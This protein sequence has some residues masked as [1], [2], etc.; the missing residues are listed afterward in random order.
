LASSNPWRPGSNNVPLGPDSTITYSSNTN[1]WVNVSVPNL[2]LNGVGP[3]N[4]PAA[5]VEVMNANAWSA[6][7]S[8]IPAWTSMPG[9]GNYRCV[10]G[11]VAGP[12]PLSPV[13][14]GTISAGPAVSDY[15]WMTGGTYPDWTT[16]N[17]RVSV[18][19]IPEGVY[20]AT[21]TFTVESQ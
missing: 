12:T 15:T 7:D 3:Q 19:L 10:W 21:I 2:L 5:N 1:Y 11:H 20:W 9:A 4:I 14:N 16:L 18:P 17:W 6:T 13:L 8:D